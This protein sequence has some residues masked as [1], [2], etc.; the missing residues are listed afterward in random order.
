MEDMMKKLTSLSVKAI[1]I[2]GCVV[3][4]SACGSSNNTAATPAV[5]LV[6]GTD[7][8]VTATETTAA[9]ISFANLSVA[10]NDETAEPLAVGEAVLATSDTDE[11]DSNV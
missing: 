4:I 9:A 3:T 11:P 5:A 6:P 7:V 10:S 2:A 8:P 1:L